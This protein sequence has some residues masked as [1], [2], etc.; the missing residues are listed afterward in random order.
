MFFNFL[1][2][3]KQNKYNNHFLKAT[4]NESNS[5]N[6]NINS[7]INKDNHRHQNL[8]NSEQI[9]TF[10]KP[11]VHPITQSTPKTNKKK[12]LIPQRKNSETKLC[13]LRFTC[14]FI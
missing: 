6:D 14:K 3:K 8:S 7:P 4:R 2:N 12:T 5:T 9:S 11:T 1:N 10:Q 13:L